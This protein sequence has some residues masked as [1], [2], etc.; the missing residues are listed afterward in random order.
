MNWL[1]MLMPLTLVDLL[2]KQIMIL[3]SIREIKGEK[4]SIAGLAT[5]ATL[6]D[7]KNKI[8]NVYDLVKKK[9]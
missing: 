5:F 7:V 3:R 8:V 4:R 1:K 6:S 9:N 2:K